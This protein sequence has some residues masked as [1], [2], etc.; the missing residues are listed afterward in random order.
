MGEQSFRVQRQ[1][2]APPEAIYRL[3]SD[4][5]GWPRWAPA[6]SKATYAREGSPDIGG[7]GAIR[8]MGR[9]G[10]LVDEEILEARAPHYQR[11]T[12]VKGLPVSSYSAEVHIEPVGSGSAL[13][14]T[15]RFKASIPGLGPILRIALGSTI[16]GL[17]TAVVTTAER[18]MSDA[19]GSEAVRP[20][21]SKVVGE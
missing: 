21:H 1:S 16:G 12:V 13:L 8:R 10:L 4:A 18:E 14:W 6:V 19:A 3:L 15:A 2:A 11:Y 20:L 9:T 17:A 5:P 7:T